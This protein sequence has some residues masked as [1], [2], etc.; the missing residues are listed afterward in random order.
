[1]TEYVSA[2]RVQALAPAR[3]A[4]SIRAEADSLSLSLTHQHLGL[5]DEARGH[6]EQALSL[7]R[8]HSFPVVEGHALTALSA[9]ATAVKL[10]HEAL[11]V[12][13][14]TGHRLGEAR[15]RRGLARAHQ[16]TDGATAEL[17]GQQALDIFS[18]IGMPAQE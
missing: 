2:T 15:T 5:P 14:E 3:K 17:M 4:T 11:A 8:D 6:A 13:R 9:H 10:G 1:M 7:A 16:E 18:D 12:H